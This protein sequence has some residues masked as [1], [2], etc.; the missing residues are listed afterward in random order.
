MSR[1]RL[2][3][4]VDTDREMPHLLHPPAHLAR[5]DLFLLNDA[6]VL[7]GGPGLMPLRLRAW[8]RAASLE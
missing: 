8:V 6:R 1:A 2:A 7:I 4:S 5:L 3:A